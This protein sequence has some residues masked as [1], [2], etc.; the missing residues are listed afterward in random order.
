MKRLIIGTAL[1]TI[2]A[3]CQGAGPR[4]DDI[5]RSNNAIKLESSREEAFVLVEVNREV[6]EKVA[7]ATVAK[8]STHFVSKGQA[9]PVVIGA[10]DIL[11][12]AIVSTN[13][14][15]FIDFSQS[16]ISPVSTTDLPPQSVGSD[17]NV[18]V[19]PL[20]RVRASGQTVQQ[21]ETFLIRR[22]GEVLV[23]PSVIVNLSDRRS[24]RVSV[25]GDVN[26]PGP[27][28]INE[29]SKHLIDVLALAGGP[30]GRPEDLTISLSRG[31]KTGSVGVA[32]LLSNPQ[33]N[34]H[35]RPGDVINIEAKQNRYTILG[36]TTANATTEFATPDF[37]LADALGAAGGVLNRRAD[38]EGVFLYREASKQLIE[39]L[40]VNTM[41]LKT[42]TAPTVFQFD[43]TQ[44][45]TLFTL[46]KFK[47]E[48]GDIIYI[49]DSRVEE[50]NAVVGAI[51]NIVPAPVEYVRDATIGN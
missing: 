23:D 28:S 25:L 34:A 36:A 4:T 43:L 50:I 26:I 11:D 33:Y 9:G 41:A 47:I 17:G 13:Q 19:P 37:S 5:L 20:G 51:T 40:G 6:A 46:G 31:G 7:A 44:P 24:A 12:I 15:G 27:Y 2:L 42:E 10:G 21:F 32:E 39:S 29:E 3:A 16:S 14:N 8:A 48:E 18:N 38:K 30:T 35:L 22:L 1:C 49:S 45:T